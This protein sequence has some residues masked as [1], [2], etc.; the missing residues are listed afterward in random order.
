MCSIGLTVPVPCRITLITRPVISHEE[1][2]GRIVTNSF[3][4]TH[5]SQT[6]SILHRIH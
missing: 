6:I 5:S 3:I 1:R 2:K 4:T